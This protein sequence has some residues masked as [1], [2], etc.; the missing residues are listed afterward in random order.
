MNR[1]QAELQ[2]LYL[3]SSQGQAPAAA[4]HRGPLEPGAEVRALVLELA[5]PGAWEP[6][7]KL[8]QGVQADLQLPAPGIAVNGSDAYQLWFSLLDPVPAAEAVS[9]LKGLVRRYLDAVAQ[10]RIRMHPSE[11]AGQEHVAAPPP[12][13]RAT[14]RWSAFV[15]PDLA[16]VFA[17]E[18]WLDLPPS[19]DAQADVLSRL[20]SV[21][22][23][24]WRQACEQL[25]PAETGTTATGA[26]SS[27]PMARHQ[28]ARRFLL[29]VMN[30]PAVELHLRIEAAKALLPYRE[31][32]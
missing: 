1:L 7:G 19:A 10:G 25:W 30:D 2:R 21:S 31:G 26:A 18:P 16:A 8:W 11:A 28:D 14:D 6:L 20:Q 23:N 9:F 15:T 27:Q 17:D 24:D 29:E 12:T 13:Q 22:A 32:P 3:P 4:G 5:V